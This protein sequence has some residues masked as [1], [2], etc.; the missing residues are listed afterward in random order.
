MVLGLPGPDLPSFRI[1]AARLARALSLPLRL[2]YKSSAVSVPDK[3]DFSASYEV[4]ANV[5]KLP[6]P[7][8]RA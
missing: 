1:G 3:D 7:L 5:A 8:Y 6:K 4:A 2:A